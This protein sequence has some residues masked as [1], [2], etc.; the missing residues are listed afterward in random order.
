MGVAKLTEMDISKIAE[1]KENLPPEFGDGEDGGQEYVTFIVTLTNGS[2]YKIE[3][4]GYND[5]LGERFVEF[6]DFDDEV[7]ASF[8]HDKIVSII[9]DDIDFVIKLV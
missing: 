4:E 2:V 3:C 6:T 9:M 1:I 7:V 8:Y 5:D